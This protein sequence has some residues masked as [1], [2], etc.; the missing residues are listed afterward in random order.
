MLL[1][2]GV[3]SLLEEMISDSETCESATALYLNLSILDDAKPE[4]GL[5]KALDFLVQLLLADNPAG[6]SCKHDALHT[7]YNISTVVTNTPALLASGI[8][9]ALQSLLTDHAT[10]EGLAWTEKALA[11]VINLA[12]S[13]AGKDAIVTTPGMISCLAAVLDTG[14]PAEQELV[15]SCLLV[16]CNGDERCSHL[17]LQEGVIPALVSVS[18]TGSPRG[19]ERAQRLL[20]LFREQ[21]QHE[22][23][24][25][26]A[27]VSTPA[28]APVPQV[29]SGGGGG[30]GGGNNGKLVKS[31]HKS[32]SKKLV[33]TLSSMWKVYQCYGE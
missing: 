11:V 27:P 29:T 25:A 3:L 33:R 32:K 12:Y 18:V 19:M 15:V 16:L 13:E 1:S 2:A 9:C 22:P 7:I 10:P 4:I 23:P 6:I 5:S 8:I 20:Q 21:R 24:P 31:L 17:V 30:G 14:E 26:A 28:P